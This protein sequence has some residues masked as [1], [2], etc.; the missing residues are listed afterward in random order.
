MS[1]SRDLTKPGLNL[2]PKSSCLIEAL[3]SRLQTFDRQQL[4]Q[5]LV[6]VPT[7]RLGTYLQARLAQHLRAFIPP[8]VCTL[9]QWVRQ[10]AVTRPN[11]GQIISAL[12]LELLLAQIIS[13][14]K[15]QHV[16]AGQERELAQLF[17]ELISS[18]IG[19]KGFENLRQK[20]E[21]DCFHNPDS[22]R[23]LVKR[24][25]EVE[26]VWHELHEALSNHEWE[27]SAQQ[28]SLDAQ[29][30]VQKNPPAQPAFLIGFTS[31]SA[32]MLPV[33]RMLRDW[34]EA[35]VWLSEPPSLYGHVNP[36]AELVEQ[37]GNS[38]CVKVKT[39]KDNAPIRLLAAPNLYAEVE[40]VVRN[41]RACLNAGNTPLSSIA[42][43]LA[44]EVAYGNLVRS[45]LSRA[46]FKANYAI[47][48][49]F[50]Q[51]ALGSWLNLFF[52]FFCGGELITD[53]LAWL[54][55]PLWEG[56]WTSAFRPAALTE[57][58]CHRG[59]DKG[60]T[61]IIHGLSN[62]E[63]AEQVQ[64]LR[65][66]LEPWLQSKRQRPTEW[67]ST[68]RHLLEV[69]KIDQH[70]EKVELDH[71]L[72]Q[73]SKEV[74]TQYFRA[75]ERLR[76]TPVKTQS[77][78]TFLSQMRQQLN[79]QE[80]RSIG[81][82]LAGIQIL[83]IPEARYFPF[84]R[85]FILG[86]L[87]GQFPKG[88]P[89]DELFDDYLK[90]GL[91]LSG[92]Q[93]LEAREDLT[94]HL[95]SS[96]LPHLYMS[97]PIRQLGE[98]TVP[99]RFVEQ[100]VLSGTGEICKPS[101]DLICEFPSTPAAV[102]IE[103]EGA[104]GQF[105]G[106]WRRFMED[107]SA[108]RLA[109]LISCP[110]RF[111]LGRLGLSDLTL[112]DQTKDP[113]REGD[114]LHKVLERFFQQ[115]P[116]HIDPQDFKE[117]AQSKLIKLSKELAPPD[118]STGPLLVH[119]ERFAW[120]R[121]IQHLMQ[122]YPDFT[123]VKGEREKSFGAILSFGGEPISVVGKIDSIDEP[124]TDLKIITDYKRKKVPNRK[125]VQDGLEPQ[126]A[127]Y[128]LAIASESPEEGNQLVGYWSILDG[129]WNAIAGT[130]QAKEWA[131]RRGLAT[132]NLLDLK[133]I[134]DAVTDI[135]RWRK[136]EISAGRFAA[137]PSNCGFCRFVGICRRDDPQ[138]QARMDQQRRLEKRVRGES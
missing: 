80:T 71:G 35:E 134:Q 64:E 87:D 88:L 66:L 59:I 53:F 109:E 32:V 107:L 60:L 101:F 126:L 73:S 63:F 61:Q 27:T 90:R 51:T 79:R 104:E 65:C 11:R 91:G 135:W 125:Q 23:Q 68:L 30:T 120:P 115:W 43:L 17:S 37:L 20:L 133:V 6:I 5:S 119:L 96:R 48:V 8:E 92:W 81:E 26:E 24:C 2:W 123:K 46:G 85:A 127:L 136:D 39:A 45:A 116:E 106:E 36:L 18:D 44:D 72:R 114:W 31:V 137:D 112:P 38:N 84:Q 21:E 97:Y 75:I 122:I 94:F 25:D 95:L 22:L 124:E 105:N 56:Y 70:L 74:L 41:V 132:R 12:E 19:S 29:Y 47:S 111:L 110:Y 138:Q 58:L 121:F 83:S 86:C 1:P 113:R 28:L 67:C 77:S 128:S 15:F 102:E 93:A 16:R 54:H 57:I 42:I 82:P 89:R 103:V 50:H 40:E 55:H 10:Q 76:L 13:G 117:F 9:E 3:V 69:M 99:S 100:V 14:K 49:A 4:A 34:P 78:R 62:T 130:P 52:E 108:S 118:P 98:D 33:V 7:L 129:E 131:V